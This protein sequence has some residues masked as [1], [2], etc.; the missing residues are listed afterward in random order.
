MYRQTNNNPC[1]NSI[2]CAFGM[3]AVSSVCLLV[4]S[5]GD[6]GLSE[7]DCYNVKITIL[8]CDIKASVQTC[9][10]LFSAGSRYRL[11][12]CQIINHFPNH[13]ELTRKDAL[14]RNIRRYRKD[15]EKAQNI[16]AV[17]YQDG[18]YVYLDFMPD[19]FILPADY[20]LFVEEFRKNPMCK[21]IMKPCGRSRGVGIFLVDR[22]SQIRNWRDV[23]HPLNSFDS[24]VISKYIENPLLIGGKKFDLRLYVLVTSFVPLKVYLF[25]HGFCRFC[26]EKYDTSVHQLDNMFIHLT[27]VS[28]QKQGREY[29]KQ[30]GGKWNTQNLRLYLEGVLGWSETKLLFDRITWLIVHSLKAAAQQI[31]NDRH[32]F[33]CY[34]Y[35]II[36]D[37]SYKPWLIEVNAAPSLTST[38]TND[39]ILKRKLINQILDIV[40]PPSGMP[41]IRWPKLPARKLLIDFELLLDDEILMM[42]T[43]VAEARRTVHNSISK[44]RN[45]NKS[46]VKNQRCHNWIFNSSNSTNRYTRPLSSTSIHSRNRTSYLVTQRH[47]RHQHRQSYRHHLHHRRH[48]HTHH[49]SKHSMDVRDSTSKEDDL[50]DSS[51][52][53]EGN[54]SVNFKGEYKTKGIVPSLNEFMNENDEQSGDRNEVV[55]SYSNDSFEEYFEDVDNDSCSDVY[56]SSNGDNNN[57]D[58]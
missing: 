22:L 41:D 50:K 18:R 10:I 39:R 21:W 45:K 44:Y 53:T 49:H 6:N 48:R 7:F 25:K 16:F 20:T 5:P 15:L 58:I 31:T 34:G 30:H 1:K 8:K 46:L 14:A 35:D 23:H 13:Y 24:Y 32:C 36:I 37:N 52:R 38:T 29:N 2:K 26:T 57:D 4:I 12:D 40:L 28:I 33:E 47:C 54:R 56:V 11:S 42:Q 9:H 3:F 51:K 55:S 19:T 27:N 43:C 17:K